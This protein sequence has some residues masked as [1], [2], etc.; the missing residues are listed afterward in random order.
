MKEFIETIIGDPRVFEENR[1]PAHSDHVAYASVA[2]MNA[3]KSSYITDL[4]GVWRFHYSKNL[5][6]APKEFYKESYDTEGWDR[7]HVPAHIQLE[8]YDIPQ[9]VNIQYPWD[10]RE[11]VAS[12]DV[13]R[14]FN[15]VADYV[16]YIDL[17]S[18]PKGDGINISFQGVESG[19]A[20][21][22][23]GKYVGYSENSF[24]PAEFEIT[25]F[26]KKGRNKIAVRVFKWTSGSWLEDQDFFRFS[27]IFRR[28]YLQRIPKVHVSDLL[29]EPSLSDNF[30][31]AKLRFRA[32][33]SGT[34]IME[35]KLSYEGKNVLEG[36]VP[37]KAEITEGSIDI[38]APC[39]WSAEEPNLY[40]LLLVVKDSHG[41][42]VEVIRQ[43]VGFR[44]FEMKDGIMLLNGKRIVF[45]G[46]NRHEFSNKNGRVPSKDELLTDI[47]TMKR[48]NI[49]AIRT[50]HY[51]DDSALYEL[52]D[53][54]GLYLIAE[55]NMESHGTW[56]PYLRGYRPLE[57][58]LPKDREEFKDLLLDRVNSCYQ[59][60]KNHPSIL[61][62]SCGN[63]SFGGSIIHEM[64]LLFKKLD[65]TRLVHYEGLFRDRSYNDTSD[66]ESQMYPSAASIEEF[67]KE[68][69]D[70]PFICCEYSHAMGNS[71][72]GMHYY[73]DLSDREPRYQGGF[74][75]DYID[76]S[77]T[78][79]NRYGESYEA[80]GGDFYDR[81]NDGNFSGN[82]IVYGDR[83][84]SPKMQ[85]VK[86]N[87][88][89]IS[90]EFEKNK[91]KFKVINKNLFVGTDKYDCLISLLADGE[92]IFET[93]ADVKVA[94]LSSK[95]FVVPAEI[96][97]HIRD[98]D[99]GISE[100]GLDTEFALTV[101]FVL[102]EDELWASK[103][104][105][106]AFGQCVLHDVKFSVKCKKPLRCA[107]GNNN[108]G[109]YGD[110]FSV[111]FSGTGPGLISYV[112]GGKEM[113][114]KPPVP[115]FWRAP[116]DNDNGYL[117]TN[118]Y[119]Q[120]K[121]ASLY[122]TLRGKELFDIRPPYIK[123]G[124]NSV[125]VGYTY[126]IPTKPSTECSI[127]Y[128]VFGDGTVKCDMSMELLKELGDCPEFGVMMRMN[129]DYDN[130]KW[131]GLGPEETYA[132]RKRGGKIGVYKNHVIDNMAKYLVPQECGN[133]C[134][135]RLAKVTD[136]RG[137]G[138]MFYGAP[139]NF[140]A[141]PFTPH[142]MENA[143]H[144]YELPKPNYTVIRVSKAQ[145]G[146]AGDDSWGAKPHPEY[147]LP[148]SGKLSFTF[149]FRGI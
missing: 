131:Y 93:Y 119:A 71:C 111:M 21:W 122:A 134:D 73:T 88:Q 24:D 102:R 39:L 8:G 53:I 50:S 56:E 121:I 130:V 22:V 13:P 78:R 82:G 120:W 132:D 81:P 103:G 29:V 61:I 45:K 87:Y 77:L 19:F 42:T 66:M 34:G 57:Y 92:K 91:K 64:S 30:K 26:L 7:I 95:S 33:T 16:K 83:T 3:K 70:K 79:K 143:Y 90:V 148:K 142:E 75:W 4:D 146:I 101:S 117:M 27:G 54:Y 32:L 129:A 41:A 11:E 100:T 36:K 116:T 112:Y 15:P 43:L 128:E 44:K 137:R 115:N 14:L 113:M 17:P 140:S 60:D 149:C 127:T 6:D 138:L 47:L 65:K 141:L 106:V 52:C 144:A 5:N 55:N 10:G 58:V 1:L 97:D 135:V 133:K 139:F 23:N 107:W 20:L 136:E 59:R 86:F 125:T 69:P 114:E 28:V 37:I 68:N 35:L 84:P 67:L 124:K 98:Y 76:Q 25:G 48:N 147:L 145:M 109:V 80:Y 12:G 40:E 2:E 63:E 94:P 126:Y 62:W 123:E 99:G 72:G 118:S 110:D 49:N 85:E 96:F 51:P 89:N 38:N 74:I 31:K 104:H 18:A 9:Y 108:L 105:E 46:V